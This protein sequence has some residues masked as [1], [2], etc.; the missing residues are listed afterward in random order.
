MAVNL[1]LTGTLS[2]SNVGATAT[3]SGNNVLATSPTLVTPVLGVAS[4]TSINFGQDALNYYDEGTFTP[5]LNFNGGTT[6]ITYNTQLG[7]YT[8]IGNQ[9]FYEITIILTSKGSSTGVMIIDGFPF[10]SASGLYA[11]SNAYVENVTF[12][13]PIVFLFTPSATGAT[14]YQLNPLGVPTTLQDTNAANNSVFIISG[15]FAI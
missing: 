12:T 1:T 9:L 13:Y 2:A 6:G 15:Q 14:F 5:R 4:A 8:R 11:V 10:T 3:G 7:K